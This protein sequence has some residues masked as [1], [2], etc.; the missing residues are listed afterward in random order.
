M[1]FRQK[2]QWLSLI[3]ALPLLIHNISDT[4]NVPTMTISTEYLLSSGEKA[5]CNHSF[6]H[7]ITK[8][9]KEYVQGL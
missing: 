9:P 5:T 1:G 2:I 8:T 3:I 4:Y 7:S 6:Q